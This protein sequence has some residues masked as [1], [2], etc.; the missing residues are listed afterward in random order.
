VPKGGRLGTIPCGRRRS[1]DTIR[2]ERTERTTVAIHLLARPRVEIE[3][4]A[5]PRPRG[6][7]VWGLL[8]F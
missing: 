5:V 1:A 7:K 2:T 4:R 3:G 6:K 8:A